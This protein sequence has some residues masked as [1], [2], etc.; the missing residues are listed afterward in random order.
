M[1]GGSVPGGDACV[2]FNKAQSVLW[3]EARIIY[4]VAP[5]F[6]RLRRHA[7]WPF[8]P[9]G[10]CQPIFVSIY[11]GIGSRLVRVVVTSN[12]A[13][14]IFRPTVGEGSFR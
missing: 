8:K 10:Q 5:C 9:T 4:P 3:S 2:R 7:V 13:R 1:T 14:A 12:P 6:A 11:V